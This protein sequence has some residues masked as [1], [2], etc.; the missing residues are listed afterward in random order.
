MNQHLRNADIIERAAK[1][2][3]T[4]GWRRGPNGWAGKV[5]DKCVGFCA[6]G[7]L[8]AAVLGR[9]PESSTEAVSV[10][11]RWNTPGRGARDA[12]SRHLYGW[13]GN[14]LW[15]WNDRASELVVLETFDRAA[16]KERALGEAERVVFDG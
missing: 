16:A 12:V 4:F 11:N 6:E 3:R 14:E 2:I 13:T 15:A 10:L 5:G 8:A 7:A 1:M 9:A